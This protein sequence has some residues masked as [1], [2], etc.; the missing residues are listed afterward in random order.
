MD[1]PASTFWWVA[2]GIAVAAE[3][4]TGTFYLLMMA[5][6]LAAAAIGA[7]LGLSSLPLIGRVLNHTDPKTTAIYARLGDDRHKERQPQD[8]Q[9]R[10]EV[11]QLVQSGK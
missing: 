9:H 10:I 6:G 3:L 8:E 7:H 1:L 11:N 4:A 5:L 2:A